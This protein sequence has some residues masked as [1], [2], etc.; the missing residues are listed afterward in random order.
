MGFI[1]A[2]NMITGGSKIVVPKGTAMKRLISVFMTIVVGAM[3]ALAQAKEYIWDVIV[4]AIIVDPSLI[5]EEVTRPIDVC[6]EFGLTYGQSVAYTRQAPIGA[7]QGRIILT[8]DKERLWTLI[9]DYCAK[10]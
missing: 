10:L 6:A 3:T 9:Y 8:V 1:K 5:T 4:A 7:Q 2:L